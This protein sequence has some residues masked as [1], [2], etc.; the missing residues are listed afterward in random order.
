MASPRSLRGPARPRTATLRDVLSELAEGNLRIDSDR[1]GTP[2]WPQHRRRM[3]VDSVLR[4]WP[5]GP[6]YVITTGRIPR[7]IDG[8]QRL[9]A[10]LD[11]VKGAFAVDGL[12]SPVDPVL[13]E[14]DGAHYAQLS[15]GMRQAVDD[16]PIV[17][18]ELDGIPPE[19][20][21]PIFVRLN[22]V[23]W[24][25]PEQRLFIEA[26]GLGEQ[27][28]DLVNQAADRG[29]EPGRIG[30]SNVGLAYDEVVIRLLAAT[31]AR[32]VSAAADEFEKRAKTGEP[33]VD[34]V[35]RRAAGS[36]A[37]LLRL[38]SVDGA[39]IRFSKATLLSWLLLL[40]QADQRFGPASAH[41]IGRLLE[42]FERQRRRISAGLKLSDPPPVISEYP[43]LPYP[44]LL[45]LFNEYAA[46]D[47]LGATQ[48]LHRD[49]VLW[50]FL[51]ACGGLPSESV[52][53]GPRLFRLY[54]ALADGADPDTAVTEVVSE[55]WGAW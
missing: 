33:V 15:T 23:D 26:G 19:H 35:K 48:I 30:F 39:G 20:L 29:L 10:L 12:L 52:S 54:A 40:V 27:V 53:P 43:A 46:I 28:R 34:E 16:Y 32:Q 44:E 3:V 11:F 2:P 31:E 50:L 8:A 42:W 22:G 7:V 45:N 38:P 9:T 37:S 21:R 49:V 14:L 36:L 18:I 17:V 25:T 24:L 4:G 5:I 6:V 13:R 1:M 41:H 55:G 47:A 51:L